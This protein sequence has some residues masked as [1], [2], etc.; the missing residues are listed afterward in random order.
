MTRKLRV[1]LGINLHAAP[2]P[3]TNPNMRIFPLQNALIDVTD[4]G[5]PKPHWYTCLRSADELSFRLVDISDLREVT[6]EPDYPEVA[7]AEF[8]FTNPTTGQTSNPFTENIV[9]WKIGDRHEED[10]QS[11]VYSVGSAMELPTWDFI[12]LDHLDNE[13]PTLELASCAPLKFQA[14]ELAVVLKINRDG[15]INQYVFDPEM[16]VDEFEGH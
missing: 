15:F 1:E 5:D 11:P 12:A 13:F 3:Q 9:K 16:I 10:L 14:F 4:P 7:L 6:E 8:Y 2:I